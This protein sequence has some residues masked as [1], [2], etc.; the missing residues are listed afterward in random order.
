MV[1]WIFLDVGNVI[2][3]DNPWMVEKKGLRKGG[4]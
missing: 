2:F 4:A 3:N 1:K